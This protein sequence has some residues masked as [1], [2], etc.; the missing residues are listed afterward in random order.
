MRTSLFGSFSLTLAESVTENANCRTLLDRL[1]DRQLFTYRKV[2]REPSYQYHDLFREFLRRNLEATCRSEE[3]GALYRKAGFLLA[4]RGLDSEALPLLCRARD[5][6]AAIEVILR[7]APSLLAQGRWKTLREW[8]EELPREI[9]DGN[10]WLLYWLGLARMQVDLPGARIGLRSAF[11]GFVLDRQVV[12]QL[13]CAAAQIKAIYFEYEDFARMDEWISHIDHLLAT[14]PVFP[15]PDAEL[16]VHSAML[17]A[18][19]YRQPAHPLLPVCR[20]RVG[21]L[22]DA[23]IDVNQKLSAAIALLSHFSIGSDFLAGEPLIQRISP[24]LEAPELTA[25]NQTYWWLYAGYH[26]HLLARRKECDAAFERCRHI[27][28]ESGLVQA[29]VVLNS[30]RCYHLCQWNDSRF[31]PALEVLK[32][33]VNPSRHMDVAQYHLACMMMGLQR[34]EGDGAAH[35]AK[36]GLDAAKRIGSSFFDVAWRLIGVTGLMA[37]GEIDLAEQWI[38]EAHCIGRGTFLE[39][40]DALIFLLRSE[41]AHSRGQEGSEV[42]WLRMAL[43][44]GTHDLADRYFRWAVNVKDAALVRAL[45]RQ[46]DV[47]YVQRLIRE[48]DMA[49]PTPAPEAWPWPVRIFTMGSFRVEIDG[50][51]LAFGHKAPKRPIA[52]LKAIIALG[53]RNVPEYR[54]WDA[55]WPGEDGGAAHEAFAVSLHRLRKLLT[56]NEAIVLQEGQVSLDPAQ[57]W[58]DALA[59]DALLDD[60]DGEHPPAPVGL[61]GRLWDIYRGPFLPEDQDAPWTISLR[62]RLRSRF[63]RCVTRTAKQLLEAGDAEAAVGL[64]RRGIETDDLAEE[65]YQGLMLCL[66]RLERRAEAIAVF[67]RFRQTLSVTLGV[68][69]SPQSERLFRALQGTELPQFPDSVPNR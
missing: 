64:Y 56:R 26:Y 33:V 34:R 50:R 13:L 51:P 32:Q 38:D 62:E 68:S 6:S 15:D 11:A 42:Q 24:L 53:G 7:A 41:L 39:R 31:G 29:E 19:T 23:D 9:I 1:C 28:L 57:C 10:S 18:A 4:Q 35:H 58:V 55:L 67:R 2:G 30:L 8:I 40:L 66:M 49:P 69:P 44:A 48:F 52:L 36:A 59:A 20:A 5:W 14:N 3:L 65:L 46:I 21:Q 25:L 16:F 63:L 61:H 45:E 43:A 47:A 22:L 60:F 27:A 12:G 54:L 37:S 17:L